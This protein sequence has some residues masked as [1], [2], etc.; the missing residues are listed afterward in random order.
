MNSKERVFS[1]V[2]YIL[3]LSLY[4]VASKESIFTF[5]PSSLEQVNTDDPIFS[6]NQMLP[7]LIS[8]TIT[9]HNSSISS[10]VL[11]C[12]DVAIDKFKIHTLNSKNP[13]R[14][15]LMYAPEN[16]N[17]K[18]Q[19]SFFKTLSIIIKHVYQ[20]PRRRNG[21]MF[22]KIIVPKKMK[23]WFIVLIHV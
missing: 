4:S 3:L 1:F 19:I 2:P 14:T 6:V 12:T 21:I 8:S 17:V 20:S 11:S 9:T 22:V 23:E 16:V 5:E 10:T 7:D 18:I 15:V 13:E